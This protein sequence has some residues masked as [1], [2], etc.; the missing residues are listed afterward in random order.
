M[1]TG[2]VTGML[3]ALLEPCVPSAEQAKM[4]DAAAIVQMDLANMMRPASVLPRSDT[5]QS[6]TR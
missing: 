2:G 6:A 3:G 4:A 5:H 1:V